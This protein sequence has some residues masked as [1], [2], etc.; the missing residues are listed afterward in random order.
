MIT[1][2]GLVLGR[3]GD[4]KSSQV[5][6]LPVQKL[7]Q[8]LIH[9]SSFHWILAQVGPKG[10]TTTLTKQEQRLVEN[11]LLQGLNLFGGPRA[12]LYTFSLWTRPSCFTN[13][14]GSSKVFP[15]ESVV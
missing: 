8:A 7:L 5:S 4:H 1:S 13:G 6:Q 2:C 15:F 3:C 12:P 11:K 14:L 9:P 10:P